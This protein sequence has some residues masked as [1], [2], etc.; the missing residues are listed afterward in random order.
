MGFAKKSHELLL[1]H[2]G[3]L[4]YVTLGF[5]T[6]ILIRWLMKIQFQSRKFDRTGNTSFIIFLIGP[7]TEEQFIPDL[8]N[9]YVCV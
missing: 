2:K 5:V 7:S 1:G 6:K 4:R 8:K 3:S 9:Y